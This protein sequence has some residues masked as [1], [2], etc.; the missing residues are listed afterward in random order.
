MTIRVAVV[1]DHRRVRLVSGQD[2]PESR[3]YRRQRAILQ[4]SLR[5]RRRVPGRE[6]QIV[7]L[8]QRQPEGLGQP[9]DHRAARRRAA[10][11]DEA[12]VALG[13]SGAQRQV[14]LA[15]LAAH[16][17]DTQRLGEVHTSGCTSG[18]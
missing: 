7:A 17:A 4:R 3:P 15:E 2:V 18:H 13:R 1:D 11:L 16:P 8:P 14:E 9:H 6:Q 5:V 10:A 12:D